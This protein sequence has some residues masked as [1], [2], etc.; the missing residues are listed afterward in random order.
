[1]R[2][3]KSAGRTC[4][5]GAAYLQLANQRQEEKPSNTGLRNRYSLTSA[6][7]SNNNRSYEIES[8]IDEGLTPWNNVN[9][10]CAPISFVITP[11]NILI[12]SYINKKRVEGEDRVTKDSAKT[13]SH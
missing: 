13:E 8:R 5:E 6:Q 4:F 12:L 3:F 2:V 1:M 11:P 7:P 10:P 9:L